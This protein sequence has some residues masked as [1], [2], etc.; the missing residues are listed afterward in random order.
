MGR[1]RGSDY[2]HSRAGGFRCAPFPYSYFAL[3]TS[4][5]AFAISRPSKG[6]RYRPSPTPRGAEHRMNQ[7]KRVSRGNKFDF[8]RRQNKTP[9]PMATIDNSGAQIQRLAFE[10]RPQR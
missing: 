3:A 5:S 6:F 1:S 8:F 7:P 9:L 2:F 10:S 4:Q